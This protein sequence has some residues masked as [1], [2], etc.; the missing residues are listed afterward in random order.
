M[1]AEIYPLRDQPV[2]NGYIPPN[3][4]PWKGFLGAITTA[5][6]LMGTSALFPMLPFLTDI[7]GY[8]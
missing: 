3:S 7:Y 2:N 8:G 6:S 5:L 1:E 4:A